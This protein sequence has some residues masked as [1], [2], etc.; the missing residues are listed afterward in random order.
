MKVLIIGDS[1]K[2]IFVYGYI[3]RLTP[4]AP[5]PVFNPNRELSNDG[6]AKNVANNVEAL[7]CTIY[8][9]T[10]PNSIKKVR[11]VDEK[12][13]QLVLRVDEHDYCDRV[14]V[15]L[16]KGNKCRIGLGGEVEVGAI[17]ISDYCKGFLHED[18]IEYI[19]KN[20]IN[21]FVDTKKEL[22]DWINDV[23]YL[24]INSSEYES[25]KKFFKDN[26]IMDKTIVTKGN[27]GCL[28]QGR[29]YPTEDVLVKDISGAGDT[30]IAGLVVKY[31]KTNDIEKAIDFAQE[32][33]KIVVQ[34]H[35]VSTV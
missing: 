14:A 29:I 34:K 7:G 13:K 22:G 18:D 10:N 33:T 27:E 17:I 25:N 23:D 19:A 32:C 28:F 6:M 8:T 2:D 16:P 24:K 15:E 30:F 5:V 9:I 31:L 20:N 12:S 3:N 1:C 35:G 11:Y 26:D 4:E 21:V